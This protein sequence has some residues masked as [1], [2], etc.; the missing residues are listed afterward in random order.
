M[1]LKD[2]EGRTWVV[3]GAN[4][5]IGRVTAEVLAGR[6]AHVVLA[7][8][9]EAKTRPVLDAIV[10]A[11]G[12]AEFLP[13]DLADLGSAR[14]AAMTL[15]ERAL[16]IHGLV[17]NAG[18]AAAGGLT[19]QG[20]EQTFGVNHLGPFVFTEH[21]LDALVASA[22]SRVVFVASKAHYR[23]S[24]I[25]WEKLR[26]PARTPIAFPEY[27]V[28]KLCNVLYA[29]ELARRLEGRDV[30]TYSLHPG[31]VASDV[32]RSLPGPLRGVAKLFM[33]S[34]EDGAKTTLFCATDE[35]LGHES[36]HYYDRCRVRTPSALARDVALQD[37]LVAKSRA[38]ASGFLD[39]AHT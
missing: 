5:G 37:L 31:V 17:N 34:N 9:S 4:T 13:I 32:W 26:Q 10:A 15:R 7:C 16:P 21:L 8:R 38:F 3:T 12:S 24:G 20:F 25:D 30:S 18:L 19:T 36:G 35:T 33:L 22:P 23:T 6:G 14:A 29:S 28:S 11:G 27:C 2:L 1:G 39:D